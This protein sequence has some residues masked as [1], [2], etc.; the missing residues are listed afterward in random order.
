MNWRTVLV[1]IAFL[2]ACVAAADP[3]ATLKAEVTIVNYRFVPETVK[4]AAGTTVTWTN[5]DDDAHTVMDGS[6]T[7]RSGA[8]DEGEIFSHT[9]AKQGVYRIAC[10]MHPQ[11]SQTIVVE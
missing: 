10:S 3:A 4:V 2:P 6:G 8:L 5:R 11:M 7:F 9:F 1:A